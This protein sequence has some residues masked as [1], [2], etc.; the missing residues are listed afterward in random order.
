MVTPNIAKTKIFRLFYKD[1]RISLSTTSA[2][3]CGKRPEQENLV[4]T[5][6][7]L[8]EENDEP[9]VELI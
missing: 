3:L 4:T 5:R 8:L 6:M 1:N 2:A 7:K 9:P